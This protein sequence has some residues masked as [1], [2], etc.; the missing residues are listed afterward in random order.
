[1]DATVVS[2]C[3][4]P[5]DDTNSWDLSGVL[6]AGDI[7]DRHVDGNDQEED[8]FAFLN[9]ESDPVPLEGVDVEN[10]GDAG[11]F[12]SLDMRLVRFP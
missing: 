5:P 3:P 11:T 12:A 7:T 4:A 8:P 2:T 10:G 9:A 1:M 6:L